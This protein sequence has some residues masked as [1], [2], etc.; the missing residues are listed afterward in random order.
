MFPIFIGQLTVSFLV[1]DSFLASNLL[2]SLRPAPE[3][4]HRDYEQEQ[5]HINNQ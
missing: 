2:S 4:N 3:E 1:F 5:A